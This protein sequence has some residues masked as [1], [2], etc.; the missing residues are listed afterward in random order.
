MTIEPSPNDNLRRAWQNQ[1]PEGIRMSADEVRRK[2][3]KFEKRIFWRN[4][5]EYL[6]ALAVVLFLGF[7]FGHTRDSMTRSGFALMIAGMV[8]MVWHLH[9]KGSSRTQ[10]ADL[11]LTH[12][13]EFFRRELERQR[14]LLQ[15]V[16]R[17]YLGPMIPGWVVLMVALARTNPGHL[18]HFV[19]AFSAFQFVAA[20][21]FVFVWRLNL[22]AARKLQRQID[23]LNA[24]GETR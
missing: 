19:L 24:L 21:L 5:R 17:W 11:A 1:K 7:Q 6:A 18:H 16:G 4:A 12:S 10:P 15:S 14:D 13:L 20:S 2:A 22:G 9:R 23:E 8:C 3:G